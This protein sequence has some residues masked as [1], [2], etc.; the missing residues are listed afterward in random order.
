MPSIAPI[1][2]ETVADITVLPTPDPRPEGVTYVESCF[3]P[4]GNPQGFSTGVDVCPAPD[5]GP[6]VPS[7]DPRTA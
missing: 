2:A 1:E 3:L 4:E 6:V 5:V 7:N